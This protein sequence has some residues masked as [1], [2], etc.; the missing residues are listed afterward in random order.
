MHKIDT[1]RSDESGWSDINTLQYEVTNSA[2]FYISSLTI[3]SNI[4]LLLEG[5][6]LTT[7]PIP[8]LMDGESKACNACPCGGL[9]MGFKVT[10]N[11][12]PED[13]DDQDNPEKVWRKLPEDCAD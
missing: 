5:K 3:R 9:G 11:T 12:E 4:K 8:L 7:Q 10:R 13:Q 2:F 1:H 6:G